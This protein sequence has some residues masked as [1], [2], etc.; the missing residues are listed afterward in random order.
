MSK[1][2]NRLFSFLSLGLLVSFLAS[3]CMDTSIP[4]EGTED[5][6]TT[7]TTTEEGSP[8]SQTSEPIAPEETSLSEVSLVLNGDG[9]QIIRSE[10]DE[11]ES[12]T[13][14]DS[15]G[16]AIEAVAVVFGQPAIAAAVNQDCPAGPMEF[17]SWDN[18]FTLNAMNGE[19][20][21]WSVR[22]HN[23]ADTP[24]LTDSG[25]GIGTSRSTLETAYA[26]TVTET[27][28][29]TEFY[30][31]DFLSGMLSSDASDATVEYLWAGTDCSFR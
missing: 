30:T 1:Q 19:L 31:D 20:V 12:V 11:T 5:V 22:S 13:F 16:S 10:M 17:T 8:S 14:E 9:F 4:S 24:L 2:N 18:G 7:E 29:G 26:A 23:A 3:A 15:L 25:I 27:T 21:G 28:L 6:P